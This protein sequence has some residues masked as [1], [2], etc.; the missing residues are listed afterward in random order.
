MEKLVGLEPIS[1]EDAEVLILGSM[2]SE[3]SL[4]RSEY[5]GNKRNHFWK[6]MFLL[7][8]HPELTDY[9]EK[10]VFLKSRKIALW[11]VIK[12]CR[13]KGSLDV[14][15]RDEEPNDLESFIE[16]HSNIR[17]IVCNGTKSFISFKKHIGLGRF[18]GVEVVKLP[19]TSP[20]PGKYNKTL[21]GKLQEW[22]IIRSF[23]NH[24]Q[25]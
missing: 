17:L 15:I 5:Y 7:F 4:K 2:P 9:S 12:T 13:R 23:L 25:F 24:P 6:I 14:N 8:N 11:D 1:E 22:E 20:V 3:E 19:S 16:T 18:P 10:L 21:E